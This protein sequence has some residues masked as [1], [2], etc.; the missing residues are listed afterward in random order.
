ML[1]AGLDFGASRVV[2]IE[3]GKTYIGIARKRLADG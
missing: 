1:A 3:R 2:G